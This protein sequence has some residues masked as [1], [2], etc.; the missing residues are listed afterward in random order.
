MFAANTAAWIAIGLL[1]PFWWGFSLLV[2][3]CLGCVSPRWHARVSRMFA[4]LERT[5]EE[6]PSQPAIS[7]AAAA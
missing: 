2:L 1:A 5:R 6:S 3:A 4:G 7:R